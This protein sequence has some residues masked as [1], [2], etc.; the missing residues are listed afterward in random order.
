MAD[1][2]VGPYPF[3]DPESKLPVAEMPTIMYNSTGY[4]P[5]MED[6]GTLYNP[7]AVSETMASDNSEQRVSRGDIDQK[8]FN[9]VAPKMT[10]F[11]TTINLHNIEF[12]EDIL[13]T[14]YTNPLFYSYY[15][16]RDTCTIQNIH[17][18]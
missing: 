6:I 8:S 3:A 15:G 1:L 10:I 7:W 17:S 9:N 12:H 14:R 13:S 16:S 18:V 2:E 4:I 5:T 11:S